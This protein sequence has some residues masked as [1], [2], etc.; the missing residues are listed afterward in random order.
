MVFLSN[1]FQEYVMKIK[2]VT[3]STN[4]L[5]EE[6]VEQHDITVIPMYINIGDQGF[7]D[8]I[9]ITRQEFYNQLP[10][11]DPFPTTAAPGIDQFTAAYTQLMEA[12]ADEILSIHISASLSAVMDVAQKAAEQ[13]TGIPVTVYDSG[14]LSLGIGFQAL[15]AAQAAGEGLSMSEI[16]EILKEQS[17]RTHVFAALDTLEFLKR[18]GR[19]NAVLAGLGGLLQIKPILTM[20]AGNAGAERVRTKERARQRLL[21]MAAELGTLEQVALVHTNAREDAEALWQTAKHL[22]T[23][24]AAPLSVDVTPVLGAHLGPGAVG[25][26]CISQ[27]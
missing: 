15:K 14:Q 23:G 1:Q 26:T 27:K 13:F 22:H 8:G 21:E 19:M 6:I 20:H 18:G 16:L 17:S 11:S 2:V 7:Q 24:Q 4:D 25:F 10:S 5:P 9:D 3:D 12:G